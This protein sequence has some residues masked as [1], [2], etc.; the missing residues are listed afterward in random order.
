MKKKKLI[1]D[2]DIGTDFDDAFAVL[3]AGVSEEVDFLGVTTVWSR[4]HE[5]ARIAK[6][7]LAIAGRCS[8]VCR[9][10]QANRSKRKRL[11]RI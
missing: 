10:Q 6:K 9:N 11:V 5:R 2:T 8:G 1:I 3:L 7:V 4:A